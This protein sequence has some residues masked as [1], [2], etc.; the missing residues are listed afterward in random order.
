MLVQV[1]ESP[2][3]RDAYMMWEEMIFYERRDAKEEG[4]EEENLR[5][6]KRKM[7]KNKSKEQIADE[8]ELDIVDVEKY[9]DILKVTV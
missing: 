2:E 6:I 8:L 5:A 3:A 1:K 9:L 7:E 4:R